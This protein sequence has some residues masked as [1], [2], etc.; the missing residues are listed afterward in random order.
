MEFSPK[1]AF[2][3]S[4]IGCMYIVSQKKQAESH[5]LGQTF[6]ANS[7]QGGWGGCRTGNGKKLS[8]TQACCLA[9]LCLAAA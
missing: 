5:N 8:K 2:H 1:N 4:S 3:V 9:Q 7:V 6:L